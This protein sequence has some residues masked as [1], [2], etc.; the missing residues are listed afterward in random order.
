MTREESSPSDSCSASTL[1]TSHVCCGSVEMFRHRNRERAGVNRMAGSFF[2]NCSNLLSS[3]VNQEQSFLKCLRRDERAS[4]GRARARTTETTRRR[5]SANGN[6]LQDKRRE[7]TRAHARTAR[8]R[9]FA[10]I[11]ISPWTIIAN[12]ADVFASL[13]VQVCANCVRTW[14]HLFQNP[15]DA[16]LYNRHPPFI[17][18]SRNC[19]NKVWNQT[20]VGAYEE[21]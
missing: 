19:P 12:T 3:H 15:T 17:H 11:N 14:S 7:R 18:K 1:S 13:T 21:T 10:Q 4:P 5:S 8:A 6:R 16:I 9:T 2:G 20:S